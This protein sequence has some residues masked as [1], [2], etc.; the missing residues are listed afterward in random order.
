MRHAPIS[1]AAGMLLVLFAAAAAA[2]D[3]AALIELDKKWGQAG[4]KGDTATI[5]KLLDD[6]LVSVNE[7][8]VR[9]KKEE[10]ADNEPPTAGASYEATDY[11]V[12][13]V[14][15]D[16]AIMTHRT[17][18]DDGSGEGSRGDRDDFT[19][20]VAIE[21]VPARSQTS[22]AT[23]TMPA[24]TTGSVHQD[25]T[26]LFSGSLYSDR[27]SRPKGRPNRFNDRLVDGVGTLSASRAAHRR[28]NGP[29]R[30]PTSSRAA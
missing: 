14:G 13:F 6:D 29:A 22:A 24:A 9:G 28:T 15:A 16:T 27:H 8:G 20:V 26:P 21:A 2:D 25:L 30:P 18:G 10:L 7:D 12:I 4:V 11:R 1:T 3:S 17:K 19:G 23:T 5:A